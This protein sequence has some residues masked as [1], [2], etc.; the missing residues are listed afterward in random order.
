MTAV[1]F[2]R[3]IPFL[4]LA[5]ALFIPN[6]A[7]QARG[8]LVGL[9]CLAPATAAACPVPPVTV[10]TSVGSQ[11][12]IPVLVQGSDVFSGFDIMLK[13]NHTILTP[14]GVSVT[15]S[16]LAGGSVVLECVG[17]VLKTG[18]TC[19]STDTVDTL[20]L[21]F[22]G[23]L[24]GFAPVTGLLFTA[25]FNVTKNL[26]TAIGYQTGCNPS[27]VGGTSTC[28]LFSNGSLSSPSATVQGATYTVAP[29]PTFSIASSRTEISLGKGQTGNSTITITS[30]NG[31]AG[32]VTFST[33]FNFTA[34]RP[35]VF[36]INPS[37]VVLN[38]N[39]FNTTLF[40]ISTRSNT[41]KLTYNVT[42]TASGGGIT[43]SLNIPVT[44]L[45]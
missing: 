26:N 45:P 4:L 8:Q 33:S 14:A 16:L 10:S 19:S 22:V 6:D 1:K 12:M 9:V 44:V 3:P 11:L 34:K 23:P 25:I 39:G 17:S 31:F 41:D 20:H 37:S 18:S 43:G 38:A 27:S 15:G 40:I 30:F 36:S 21:V 28:V 24:L 7:H 35:P 29:V 2:L 32:T 42:I 5:L 13:T